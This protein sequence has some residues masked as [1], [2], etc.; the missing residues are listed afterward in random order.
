MTFEFSADNAGPCTADSAPTTFEFE[1]PSTDTLPDFITV[2]FTAGDT[3]TW[4][5]PVIRS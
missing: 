2:N 1:V 5:L 4:R 3:S